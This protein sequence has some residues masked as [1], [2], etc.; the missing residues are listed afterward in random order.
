MS[1]SGCKPE[2]VCEAWEVMAAPKRVRTRRESVS[3][4]VELCSLPPLDFFISRAIASKYLCYLVQIFP[5][6]SGQAWRIRLRV[7]S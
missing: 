1:W 2:V 5:T 6:T 4:G 3:R 7:E